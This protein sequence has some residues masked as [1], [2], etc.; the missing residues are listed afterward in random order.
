MD[1]HNFI[2]TYVQACTSGKLAFSE[3]GPMW[4]L[5]AITWFLLLALVVLVALRLCQ[6][7]RSTAS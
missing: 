6:K 4:Y 1:N 5:I 3:C 2:L 7:Q